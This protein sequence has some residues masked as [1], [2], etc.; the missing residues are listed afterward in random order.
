MITLGRQPGKILPGWRPSG[1]PWRSVGARQGRARE[2]TTMQQSGISSKKP[3]RFQ[4]RT[5]R[6]LDCGAQRGAALGGVGI[7]RDPGRGQSLPL[8]ITWMPSNKLGS[9]SIDSPLA[10]P[11]LTDGNPKDRRPGVS[12]GRRALGVQAGPQQHTADVCLC[13]ADASV[14]RP[15]CR[16]LCFAL[17]VQITWTTPFRLTIL[18]CLQNRFTEVRTFI[19]ALGFREA[20]AASSSGLPAGLDCTY[21]CTVFLR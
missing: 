1:H 18:Q 9:D 3:S 5:K 19:L 14:W 10:P 12:H 11:G 20:P 17:S 7:G 4:R 16:C 6:E 2:A 8:P 13:S 21:S 15:F